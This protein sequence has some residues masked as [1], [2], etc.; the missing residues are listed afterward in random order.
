[1]Q[2]KKVY[3]KLCYIVTLF[4]GR[5]HSDVLSEDGI[6]RFYR[7]MPAGHILC[8]ERQR[9]QSALF[10]Y[11]AFTTIHLSAKIKQEHPTPH[12]LRRETSHHGKIVLSVSFVP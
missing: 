7:L 2:N 10:G 6:I 9:M 12:G 1:M 3:R 4:R 11:C 5:V 8:P